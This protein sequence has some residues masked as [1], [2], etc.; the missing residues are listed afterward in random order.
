MLLGKSHHLKIKILKFSI[1]NQWKYD[2]ASVVIEL[3]QLQN[4]EVYSKLN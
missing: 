1:Y 2:K 3:M 4:F